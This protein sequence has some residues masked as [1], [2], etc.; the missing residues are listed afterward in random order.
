M[1]VTFRKRATQYRALLRKMSYKDKASYGSSPA[2]TY[3][4]ESERAIERV[5]EREREGAGE[6]E[7]GREREG[8]GE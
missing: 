3:E 8:E 4:R 7:G 6:G 1:K 5:R 2:C